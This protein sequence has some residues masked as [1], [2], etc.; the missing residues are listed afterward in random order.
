MLSESRQV[1]RCKS[2][3]KKAVGSEG[4]LLSAVT[5]SDGYYEMQTKAQKKW[6]MR[7]KGQRKC[8][9]NV[10]RHPL[11]I[12]NRLKT[13]ETLKSQETYAEILGVMKQDI[14]LEESSTEVRWIR[15][16]TTGALFQKKNAVHTIIPNLRVKVLVSFTTYGDVTVAVL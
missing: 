8:K 16:T 1:L 9:R 10:K 11:L 4:R 14:K 2:G 3:R 15:K 5:K 7:R 13:L 12:N 6:R